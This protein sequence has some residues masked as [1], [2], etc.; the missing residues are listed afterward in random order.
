MSVLVD[1]SVW[2]DFLNG[3]S[4]PEAGTLGTLIEGEREV[5]TC[6]LV[7]TEVLQGLRRDRSVALLRSHFDDMTWLTPLEPGFY[8]R[9]AELYRALRRGG[10]TPRSV[11][12]CM[13][14]VLAETYD[15]PLLAKD[16]DFGHAIRSGC[17]SARELARGG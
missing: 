15:V 3:H 14:L 6:G 9:A 5:L 4:S 2:V 10:I 13:L 1:T 7:V 16:A 8:L 12:D 11:V 17:T